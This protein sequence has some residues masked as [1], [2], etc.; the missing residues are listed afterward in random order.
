MSDVIV[1]YEHSLEINLLHVVEGDDAHISI[2]TVPSK[3]RPNVLNHHG[4]LERI[5]VALP[6]RHNTPKKHT[7][8]RRGE[9]IALGSWEF[10]LAF[11]V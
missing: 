8:D 6:V 3:G 4:H 5:R 2:R 7:K 9:F 11:G 1:S 10:V